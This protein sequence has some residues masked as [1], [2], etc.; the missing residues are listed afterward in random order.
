MKLCRYIS[1]IGIF[2]L[3]LFSFAFSN[4]V[5][6]TDVCLSID[7]NNLNYESTSDIAGFQFDHDGCVTAASGGDAEANGF[8]ISASNCVSKRLF[9]SQL[10]LGDWTIIPS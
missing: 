9:P 7:G 1:M 5:D 3:S 2:M 8:T 10:K 4:C 6:G